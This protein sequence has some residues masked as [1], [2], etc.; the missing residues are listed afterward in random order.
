MSRLLRDPAVLWDVV[1]GVVTLCDTRSGEVFELNGTAGLLW[2][3]CENTAPEALVAL[4]VALYPTQDVARL[5]ADVESLVLQLTAAALL[6]DDR[7]ATC[8]S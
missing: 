8:Q 5:H 1:D 2:S 4:L 3:R 6:Q 7:T